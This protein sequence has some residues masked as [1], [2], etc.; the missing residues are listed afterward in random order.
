MNFVEVIFSWICIAHVL[1]AAYIPFPLK[2]VHY[3]NEQKSRDK[4]QGILL[5][6]DSGH[7]E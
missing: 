7:P 4:Y 2:N 6:L 3:D 1:L 5:G